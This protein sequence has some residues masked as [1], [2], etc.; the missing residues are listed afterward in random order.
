MTGAADSAALF[1][2]ICRFGP[3][4]RV[5]LSKCYSG[6]TVSC[7]VI[8]VTQCSCPSFGRQIV[9]VFSLGA[10]HKKSGDCHGTATRFIL[11]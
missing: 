4:C 6:T 2:C 11:L 5:S 3:L 8:F 7:F 9:Q 1:F 10:V